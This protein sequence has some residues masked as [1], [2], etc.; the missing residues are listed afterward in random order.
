MM[1]I[2]SLMELNAGP[3]LG[4]CDASRVATDAN[5]RLARN[6]QLFKVSWKGADLIHV[7]LLI[8]LPFSQV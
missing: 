1:A 3:S 8:S 5:A 2:A 6:S 7:L 4:R